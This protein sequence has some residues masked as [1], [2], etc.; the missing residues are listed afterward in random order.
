MTF[1]QETRKFDVVVIGGGPGGAVC[2]RELAAG[3]FRALV[4]ERGAA[5]RIKPCAGAI[6][7]R[8][9]QITPTPEG[10]IERL[11]T[12]A[13]VYSNTGRDATLDLGGR[14]GWTVYRGR[15]DTALRITA[16][17][18]GAEIIHN[19]EVTDVAFEQGRVLVK[20]RTPEGRREVAC[21]CL[22]GAFGFT[23]GRPLYA[24]LGIAQPEAIMA[25]CMELAL[26][27]AQ[28]D[29]QIGGALEFY[30][31]TRIV[32]D[33]YAWVY[34]RREGV[35]VGM[36]TRNRAEGG[37]LRARLEQFIDH[38]PVVSVKVG[39]WRPFFGSL[40]TSTF[41]HL[42]PRRPVER[43]FG[44]RFVLIGD[45][46]G[47]ADPLTGEGIYHAQRL[48]KIAADVL[49]EQL[50]RNLLGAADLQR[51]ETSWREA[52]YNHGIKYTN[53][54]AGMIDNFNEQDT[55]VD[56]LVELAG[57]DAEMNAAMLSAFTGEGNSREAFLKLANRRN[58][59]F[60]RKRLSW[61]ALSL[62]TALLRAMKAGKK[63]FGAREKK[64]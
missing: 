7:P 6:S 16:R 10:V 28:V 55:L 34:P 41:G 31:D 5:D 33:G 38:H 47:A 29:R 52:V 24:Q 64:S 49:T 43:S 50:Q 62:P 25:V 53:L 63:E 18:A 58:A 13:R 27:R 57:E 1:A 15:Y 12:S 40:R 36:M 46:A 9:A 60:L 26:P 3:G 61:K 54:I 17:R 23:F 4:L 14:V 59:A 8:T 56:M 11:I 20:Y 37:E 51:Y 48:G 30:F 39:G 19:A 35:S 2:A 44:D 42:I 45:A 22:A 21:R 32:R